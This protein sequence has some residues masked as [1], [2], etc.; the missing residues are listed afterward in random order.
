MTCNAPEHVEEQLLDLL[1]QICESDAVRFRRDEDLFALGL[2]D[3][4]AAVELL[5]SIEDDF[6]VSIAPTEVAREE[7]NTVNLIIEQVVKRL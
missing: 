7:M 6:G 2:L 3:S 4:M 5:V 1:E